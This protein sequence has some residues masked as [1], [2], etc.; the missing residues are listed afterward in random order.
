VQGYKIIGVDTRQSALD[1]IGALPTELAPDLTINPLD[2]VESALRRIAG[3]FGGATGV[4]ATIVATDALPAFAFATR[5]LA[6]HGTMVVV[7]LPKEPIPFHYA[8]IIFRDM[9]ITSGTPC[10]K[11][12]R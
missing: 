3:S 9:Q 8:D 12:R 1:H 4:G 5:I 7:G 6:K 2:G 10:Q 11:A